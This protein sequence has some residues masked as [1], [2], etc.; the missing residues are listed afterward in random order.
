MSSS[1]RRGRA[2]MAF[3]S[4]VLSIVVTTTR[5]TDDGEHGDV[6]EVA[7]EVIVTESLGS[8]KNVARLLFLIAATTSDR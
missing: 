7:A 4:V 5:E 1:R 3:A 2:G 6:A 8:F